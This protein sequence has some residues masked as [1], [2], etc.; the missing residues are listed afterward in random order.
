MIVMTSLN[1]RTTSVPNN[2]IVGFNNTGTLPICYVAECTLFG[3]FIKQVQTACTN[4]GSCVGSASHTHNSVSHTHT[5]C[6]TVSNHSHSGTTGGP[7]TG[8]LSK[9]SGCTATISSHSHGLTSTTVCSGTITISCDGHSHPAANNAPP[10]ITTRF[11]KFNNSIISLRPQQ[12]PIDSIVMW[13][14]LNSLTPDNHTLDACYNT[15]F[16]Q[17]IPTGCATPKATAGSV[18]HSHTGAGACHTITIPSHTHTVSAICSATTNLSVGGAGACNSSIGTH[19]HSVNTLAQCGIS[20]NTANTSDCH[21][22]SSCDLPASHE[23]AFIKKDS[24]NLRHKGIQYKSLVSWLGTLATIPADFALADG[25]LCTPNL[26]DRYP[27]GVATSCTD[28][29]TQAGSNTHIHSCVGAHAH[30]CVSVGHSHNLTGCTGSIGGIVVANSSGC[31]GGVNRPHAHSGGSFSNTNVIISGV[32]NGGHT[33][34][35]LDLKPSSKEVAI[36]QRI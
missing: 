5:L 11:I 18:S 21:S 13:P 19:G 30:N 20:G 9:P 26:I 22:H 17:G 35:N 33:H 27:K 4:P 8:V 36:I 12:L 16:V 29:G 10:N 28:P 6:P 25:T 1:L 24:H 34:D 3:K 2:I 14:L 15:R 23:V 31:T 7:T 32:S